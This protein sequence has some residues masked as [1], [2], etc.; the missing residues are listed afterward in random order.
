[1]LV[2]IPNPEKIWLANQEEMKRQVQEQEQGQEEEEVIFMIDSIGDQSLNSFGDNYI[3]FPEVDSNVEDDSGALDSE[4]LELYD[5]DRD[6][7]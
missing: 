7:S 2:P 3:A 5:L 6:Y 1:L 4:G